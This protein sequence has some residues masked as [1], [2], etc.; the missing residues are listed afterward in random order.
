MRY[1]NT[2]LLLLLLLLLQ[3]FLQLVRQNSES[4]GR[5]SE[6]V[7]CNILRSLWP[8]MYWHSL[9]HS[10]FGFQFYTKLKWWIKPSP[11]WWL[12]LLQLLLWAF[13]AS[14]RAHVKIKLLP[15]SLTHPQ[16]KGWLHPASIFRNFQKLPA[17]NLWRFNHFDTFQPFWFRL[18]RWWHLGQRK[19]TNKM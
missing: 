15:Q 3:L 16:P 4:M 7:C 17:G 10:L 12:W 13:N 11:N 5:R 9:P 2:L 19:G 1:I 8:G 18:S 6:T 14:M